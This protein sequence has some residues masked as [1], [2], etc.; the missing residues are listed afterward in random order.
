[1]TLPDQVDAL[2]VGG[3]PAGLSAA[4]W[5]GRYQ[6]MT[7]VVDAA[8]HRNR[9]TDQVH[10][11]L[12]RDPI[13]PQELITEAVAG[14]AQYPT[15][16]IHEG[17]VAGIRPPEGDGDFMATVD[18]VEVTARRIVLATGVR[19]VFPAADGFHAQYGTS[20]YHCPSC[21][22]YNARGRTVVVLGSGPHVPA[23][24]ADLLDWADQVRIVT[25]AA[26]PVFTADQ[27]AECTA[28]GID[29]VDGVA[30]A[31]IG[32]PGALEGI[33]L[34]DTRTIPADIVFFSYGHRPTNDLARQLGCDLDDDGTV[35]VDEFQLSSVAGVYAA[36][37]VTPGMQLVPI[38]VGQGALAGVA[39]ATSLH[40][41]PK[42]L[43]PPPAPAARGFAP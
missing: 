25:D 8:E 40:G 43:S 23:Y 33:R 24:A 34:A 1:M 11:Y 36:G 3:G 4:T 9:F 29:I 38:A 7:L 18:G 28:H 10:G 14:L 5:L 37:D 39:C 32:E 15:V 12:T 31:F 19:D 2:V 6:R 42:P 16:T 21:D 35:S 26:E 22:G 20:V 30:A 27:R 41:Q 13:A 17:R